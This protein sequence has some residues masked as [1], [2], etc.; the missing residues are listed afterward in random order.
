[1]W[2]LRRALERVAELV[3]KTRNE[4]FI[5]RL[6]NSKLVNCTTAIFSLSGATLD[7]EWNHIQ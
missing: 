4:T 6:D 2:D 1:V 3:E 7:S 5:E